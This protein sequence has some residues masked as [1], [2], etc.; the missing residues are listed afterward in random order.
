MARAGISQALPA[1]G[2]AASGRLAT[3]TSTA[4]TISLSATGS[5]NAPNADV[6]PCGLP[7]DT[8]LGQR[9]ALPVHASAS[10]PRPHPCQPQ[11]SRPGPVQT[12]EELAVEEGRVA[13]T[14]PTLPYPT[15]RV[16]CP[17]FAPHTHH[18]P[19]QV[20]VQEVSGAGRHEDRAA[21]QRRVRQPAEPHCR[22]TAPLWSSARYLPGYC[23]ALTGMLGATLNPKAYLQTGPGWPPPSPASAP[24][25]A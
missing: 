24:S 6:V 20:A 23:R 21:R 11:G 3:S 14:H 22:H 16:T 9:S 12:E 8:C 18:G 25:A 15:P 19:R 5:R 1:S 17:G 4:A 13:L 2:P 7:A 10:T